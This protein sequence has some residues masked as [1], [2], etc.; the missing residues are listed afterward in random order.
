MAGFLTAI[1]IFMIGA[2]VAASNGDPSGI[3]GI[4]KIIGTIAGTLIVMYIIASAPQ[5]FIVLFIIGFIAL[6]A[7]SALK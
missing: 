5:L 4:L 1:L 7:Y 6:I 2:I 3:Y